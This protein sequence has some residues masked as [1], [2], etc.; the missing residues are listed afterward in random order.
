MKQ[1]KLITEE[2]FFTIY[3]ELLPYQNEI[4]LLPENISSF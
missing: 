1:G 2:E 4:E 3:P